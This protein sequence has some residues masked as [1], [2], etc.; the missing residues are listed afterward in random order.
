VD[1][2]VRA[3]LILNNRQA[4]IVPRETLVRAGQNLFAFK[5]VANNIFKRVS[6]ETLGDH[7]DTAAVAKGLDPGDEVVTDGALLL[8]ASLAKAH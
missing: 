6:V 3:N 8:E 5:R 7:A 1:M 2:Y 4:L